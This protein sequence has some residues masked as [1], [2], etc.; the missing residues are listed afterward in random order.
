MSMNAQVSI[1]SNSVGRSG[2]GGQES[3]VAPGQ[4]AVNARITVSFELE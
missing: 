1:N 4:I 2:D 3:T